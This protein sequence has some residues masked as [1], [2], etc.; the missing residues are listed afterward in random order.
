MLEIP[1]VNATVGGAMGLFA[2]G[3]G[4]ERCWSHGGFWGTAVV[5]CPDSKVAA[6][7]SVD[8]VASGADLLGSLVRLLTDLGAGG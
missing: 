6:A 7:V 5:A 1:A 3:V 4:A 8:Q 2:V